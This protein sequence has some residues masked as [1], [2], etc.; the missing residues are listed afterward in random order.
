MKQWAANLKIEINCLN[1]RK[2]DNRVESEWVPEKVSC[3]G[4]FRAWT[5][6]DRRVKSII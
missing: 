6:E 4:H 5:Y 2:K 1:E 3:G